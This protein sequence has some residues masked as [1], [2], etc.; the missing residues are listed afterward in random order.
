MN[1]TTESISRTGGICTYD[2]NGAF[3]DW[4]IQ[5]FSSLDAPMYMPI[6][7]TKISD[8]STIQLVSLPILERLAS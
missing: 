7:S 3:P 6:G 2:L 5:M 4:E 1:K 8:D